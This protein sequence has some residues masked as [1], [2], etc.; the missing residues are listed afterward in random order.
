MPGCQKCLDLLVPEDM[1]VVPW[2]RVYEYIDHM[3]TAH[4]IKM[5]K[6]KKQGEGFVRWETWEPPNRDVR[7]RQQVA[8][9]DPRK[10]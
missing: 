7:V 4:G 3:A 5:P 8:G 6:P 9:N 1:R 10:R 2:D